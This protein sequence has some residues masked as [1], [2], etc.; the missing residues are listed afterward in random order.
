MLEFSLNKSQISVAQ[1]RAGVIITPLKRN[2]ANNANNWKVKMKASKANAIIN[3]N[4]KGI[5]MQ[6]I[7]HK[8]N[9]SQLEARSYLVEFATS[10]K[11]ISLKEFMESK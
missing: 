4:L 10:S 3:K 7:I 8:K 9:W 5:F 11:K 1:I 2:N 6:S